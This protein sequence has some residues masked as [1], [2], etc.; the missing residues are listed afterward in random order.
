MRLVNGQFTCIHRK[1]P[2]T[3]VATVECTKGINSEQKVHN[4]VLPQVYDYHI[5]L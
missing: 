1:Y 5:S 4:K 3:Y 2:Y